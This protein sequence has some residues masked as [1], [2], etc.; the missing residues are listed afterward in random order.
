MIEDNYKRSLAL[1]LVINQLSESPNYLAI[2]NA[3]AKTYDDQDYVLKRLAS[4]DVNK[5]VDVW[6]DLIGSIVGQPRKV[7]V[8]LKYTYF[9]YNDIDPNAG[10]YLDN[11]IYYYTAAPETES[12]LLGNEEYRRV[13][14]ARAAKNAGDTSIPAITS[15]MQMILDQEEVYVY[16]AGNATIQI[17]FEG[18]ISDNILALIRDGQILP[19]AAGVGL[20]SLLNYSRD[21]IFGY[22]DIDPDLNG[23]DNGEY[24]R[25]IL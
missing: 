2:I 13:I 3:I 8:N 11:A 17:L 1:S 15:T 7:D 20:Q 21:T 18:D 4:L 6:L 12:N 25:D 10:G 5:E 16:N 22:S 23:Y 14:I 9:G 24:A 19:L